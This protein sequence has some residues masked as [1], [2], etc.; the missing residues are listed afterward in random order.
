MGRRYVKYLIIISTPIILLTSFSLFYF[1]NSLLADTM[2]HPSSHLGAGEMGRK[3]NVGYR[4]VEIKKKPEQNDKEV[5]SNKHLSVGHTPQAMNGKHHSNRSATKAKESIDSVIEPDKALSSKGDVLI[6]NGRNS[7]SMSGN[8]VLSN[9]VD[10]N[11]SSDVGHALGHNSN[12]NQYHDMNPGPLGVNERHVK[13]DHLNSL[14]SNYAHNARHLRGVS[15][16]SGLQ[17]SRQNSYD[18]YLLSRPCS[19]QL[20]T[21][22]L[23]ERDL[24]NFTACKGR[25]EA[26]Y[27]KK[28]AKAKKAQV[29]SI[30]HLAARFSGGLLQPSGECRFMN[31]SGRNPMGLV[32]FPGSG[33]TWVRGLLQKATGICT[34]GTCYALC[35]A[36]INTGLSIAGWFFR[37]GKSD[38]F[39]YFSTILCIHFK[40]SLVRGNQPQG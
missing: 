30:N 6:Q 26:A 23:S 2:E 14:S 19:D 3:Q 36:G 16:H 20:C 7:I 18:L 33:N 32:S 8:R 17:Q 31:G 1:N 11:V 29:S 13:E 39:Q 12:I 35:I 25:T 15:P 38:M 37:R 27:S 10:S 21:S 34:G 24:G 40:Y 22:F 4:S 9:G 5:Q 28:L